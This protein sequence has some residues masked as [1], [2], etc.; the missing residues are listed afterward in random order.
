MANEKQIKNGL[1][2]LRILVNARMVEN[3]K[4]ECS[5]YI[6]RHFIQCELF[7]SFAMTSLKAEKPHF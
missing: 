2:C 3:N 4:N 5:N 1:V 6:V 7:H